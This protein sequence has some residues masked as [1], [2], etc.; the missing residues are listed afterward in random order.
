MRKTKQIQFANNHIKYWHPN[1]NVKKIFPV[2]YH[3]FR[4]GYH[5]DDYNIFAYIAWLFHLGEYPQRN[6]YYI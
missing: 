6:L 1:R 3:K 2:G 4:V 5:K